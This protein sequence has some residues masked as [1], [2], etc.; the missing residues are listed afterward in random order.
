MHPLVQSAIDE[1][2][3]AFPGHRVESVED[4]EGGAFVR[5]HA[6]P[7]G[8]QYSPATG[9]VTFR[10]LHTYPHADV[11]P[12]H[13]PPDLSRRDGRPLGEGFHAQHPMQFGSFTGPSTMVSRR[14]KKWVAGQDTAALKLRKVLDF[15]RTRP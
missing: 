2:T 12:H 1:L 11:Y 10:L 3:S 6:L 8:D 13:L 7:F 9:W 4:G 14:T 5:V 15:V